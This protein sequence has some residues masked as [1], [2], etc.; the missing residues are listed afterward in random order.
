MP[1][2]ET[3]SLLVWSVS[4]QSNDVPAAEALLKGFYPVME[5]LAAEI[6]AKCK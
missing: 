1:A 3:T 4:F 5:G 6:G 2:S